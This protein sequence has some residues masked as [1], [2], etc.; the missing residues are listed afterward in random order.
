MGDS[1]HSEQD[2]EFRYSAA[3]AVMQYCGYVWPKCKIIDTSVDYGT[4][5]V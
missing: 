1:V 2:A 4:T 3:T 5:I